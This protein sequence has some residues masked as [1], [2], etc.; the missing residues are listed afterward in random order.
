M[1]SDRNNSMFMAYGGTN[2]ME[3]NMYPMFPGIND[4]ENRVNALERI[5][6]RLDTRVARLEGASGVYNTET[7]YNTSLP[8]TYNQSMYPNSMH[9]M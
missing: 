6:R 1:K 7:Q 5:V 9:M 4:L 2:M 3:P 8:D